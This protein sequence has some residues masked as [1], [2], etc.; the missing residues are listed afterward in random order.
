MVLIVVN[1][2]N[3]AVDTSVLI[4]QHALDCAQMAHGTCHRVNLMTQETAVMTLENDTLVPI[5]IEPHNAI[6][7]ALKPLIE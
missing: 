5:H 7:L 6:I 1:F 3:D 4:P 2:G